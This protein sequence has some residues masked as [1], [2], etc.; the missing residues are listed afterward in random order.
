MATKS[1]VTVIP[2]SEVA[3]PLPLAE[4][5]GGWP[6]DEFTGI[7]G[8]YVR[9]PFTGVRSRNVPVDADTQPNI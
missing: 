5:E 7:G 9:D 3:G 6:V 8:S 2:A 4:P 1:T